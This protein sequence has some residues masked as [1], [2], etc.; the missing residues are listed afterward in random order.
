MNF[1]IAQNSRIHE[2]MIPRSHHL[3]CYT[4]C[5]AVFGQFGVLDRNPPGYR[6]INTKRRP[7]AIRSEANERIRRMFSVRVVH[8][9]AK[10]ILGQAEA[11]KHERNGGHGNTP[12]RT[13][14]RRNRASGVE[15]V[16]GV[17]VTITIK[18]STLRAF[19]LS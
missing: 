4:C 2:K 12:L 14:R 8:A 11:E 19:G 16:G 17:D 9:I 13:A 15:S 3:K 5:F 7:A 10:R 1:N 6:I 18:I